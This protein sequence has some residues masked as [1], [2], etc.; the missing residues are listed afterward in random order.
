MNNGSLNFGV[1]TK[2]KINYAFRKNNL[3]RL[4]QIEF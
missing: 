4:I 3:G 2:P 1:T